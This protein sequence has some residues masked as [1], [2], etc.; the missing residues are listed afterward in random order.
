MSVVYKLF[1]QFLRENRLYWMRTPLYIVKNGKQEAYYFTDE[2]M[3]AARST[4]KGEVTRAKGI[5]ALTSEQVYNSMFNPKYQ[6]LE[7]LCPTEESLE[8]LQNLMGED[9]NYRK[10]F[11]FSHVDFSKISE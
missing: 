4:L 11:I 1:P 9:V 5:G 3:D 8:L 10:D 2:E 7:Q 6:R